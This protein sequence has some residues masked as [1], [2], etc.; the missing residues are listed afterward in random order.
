MGKAF[1]TFHTGIIH[2]FPNLGGFKSVVSC[3][4]WSLLQ[5][6]AAYS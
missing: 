3:G 2:S 5:N 1:E 4:L 6:L